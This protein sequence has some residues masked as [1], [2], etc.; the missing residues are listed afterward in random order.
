[1]ANITTVTR[2]P[3]GCGYQKRGGFYLRSDGPGIACGV[4]PI[5]LT[6]CP[7]CG[8]GIKQSR[9]VTWMSSQILKNK[10]CDKPMC[11]GC[12]DKVG[13]K[14]LLIWIGRQFYKTPGD[15]VREASGFNPDNSPMGF[16]RRVS[17]IPRGF[18]VGETWVALAHLDTVKAISEDGTPEMRPGIFMLW[19]PQYIEYIVTGKETEEEL[20]RM[21]EQGIRLIDVLP[22][23]QQL[24][25]EQ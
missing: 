20:N 16:S 9:A 7:C 17:A 4:L 15:F 21:E 25:N 12:L 19:C 11:H 13:D 5:E 14:L 18:K 1:M 22:A 24:F 10:P 2:S 6:V 23:Q 3:R 8:Q